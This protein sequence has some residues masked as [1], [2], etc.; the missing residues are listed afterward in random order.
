MAGFPFGGGAIQFFPNDP[1]DPS[2]GYTIGCVDMPDIMDPLALDSI[3][4]YV[5]DTDDNFVTLPDEDF[6]TAAKYFKPFLDIASDAAGDSS[7]AISINTNGAQ[8]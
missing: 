1:A 3:P 2:S 4:D 5:L 6:E 7:P 8:E